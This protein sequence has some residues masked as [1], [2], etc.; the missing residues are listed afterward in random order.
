M[1]N[2]LA[3]VLTGGGARA[4]YQVGV[5]RFL[6]AKRPDLDVPILTGVSAG[7]INAAFLGSSPGSFAAAAHQLSE[8]WLQMELDTL[9]RT[10]AIAI[11]GK[12]GRWGLRLSS[13][14]ARFAPEQQGLVDTQPMRHFL[15]H[16]LGRVDGVLEGLHENLRS[17]RLK[18]FALT[19]IDW[20]SGETVDWIA[21]RHDPTSRAPYRRAEHGTLTV[22]HVMASTSLPILFPAVRLK[23]SWYGDGGIRESDPLWAAQSL[24]AGRILAVS[25]RPAPAASALLAPIFG[26]RRYPPLAQILGVLSNAIFLDVLDDDFARL[27]ARRRLVEKIPLAEREGQRPV[28]GMLLRPSADLGA[29]AAR[30]ERQLPRA[31]RF[32]VGGLGTRE[33][34]GGDFLSLVMFVPEYLERVMDLGEEDAAA[35]GDELLAFVD[36]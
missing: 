27:E 25:T 10:G 18:S 11:A 13:G 34:E 35:R 12:V 19:A 17:G 21:G 5:L 9:L 28:R 1:F 15:E 14:G 7:S 29:L 2:D 23:E 31:F 20:S 6:A 24:G 16:H 26:R 30:Y 33:S 8:I 22:E 36:G 4:A 3:L 32:L